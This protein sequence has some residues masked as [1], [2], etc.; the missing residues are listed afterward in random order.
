M[1]Q[2]EDLEG[3]LENSY[4]ELVDLA[5]GRGLTTTAESVNRLERAVQAARKIEEKLRGEDTST[6]DQMYLD[7]GKGIQLRQ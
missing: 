3:A 1:A 6:E 4:L 5:Q 2:V 7:A